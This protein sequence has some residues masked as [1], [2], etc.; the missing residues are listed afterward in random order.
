MF[1][2]H[3]QTRVL[4]A[5]S[6]YQRQGNETL[7]YHIKKTLDNAEKVEEARQVKA[8]KKFELADWLLMQNLLNKEWD[9]HETIAEVLSPR[10]Y[11]VQSEMGRR[12]DRNG[13]CLRP[14]P[15]LRR[16]TYTRL[17]CNTCNHVNSNARICKNA[18][19]GA[20]KTSKQKPET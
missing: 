11:K 17:S 2:H 12:Y 7:T 20:R 14:W 19:T 18:N 16:N 5:K 4:A 15:R 9:L 1:S 13:K 6:N 8:E 3:Q 10:R